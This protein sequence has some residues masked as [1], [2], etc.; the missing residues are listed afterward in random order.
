MTGVDPFTNKQD[1]AQQA[2]L[3]PDMLDVRLPRARFADYPNTEFR[4]YASAADA[5]SGAPALVVFYHG[6]PDTAPEFTSDVALD[7]YLIK[8]VVELR[9]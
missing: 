3:V 8:R 9:R 7:A 2:T 4:F 1:V 6:V 5:R